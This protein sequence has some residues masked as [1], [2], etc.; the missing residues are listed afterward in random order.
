MRSRSASFAIALSVGLLAGV[1]YPYIELALACRVPLS[2]ACVW[3]KAFF[4]LSRWVSLVLVGGLATGLV[5]ALL[6]WRRKP[7]RQDEGN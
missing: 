7:S 1:A 5:Y 4:A 2:E 3:G 6:R